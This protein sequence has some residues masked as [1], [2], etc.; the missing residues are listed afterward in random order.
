MHRASAQ[1]MHMQM[2]DGLAAV[3]ASID[4][5]SIA[6]AEIL[7]SGEFFCDC[8]QIAQQSYVGCIYFRK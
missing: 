8:M 5:R 2:M 7:F 6:A 4:N 3:C 1:Q